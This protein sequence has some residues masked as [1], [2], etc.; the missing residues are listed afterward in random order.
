MNPSTQAPGT[1][2][3]VG[4]CLLSASAYA[5]MHALPVLMAAV[6]NE[7]RTAVSDAGWLVTAYM[8]GQ[9]IA[10]VGLPAARTHLHKSWHGA[11]ACAFLI[12]ALLMSA[13]ASGAL[14]V[15]AWLL[16]GLA[17]GTLYYHSTLVVA[18]FPNAALAFSLRLSLSLLVSA[19]TLVLIYALTGGATY[20]QIVHG[21]VVGLA[22]FLAAGLVFLRPAARREGSRQVHGGADKQATVLLAI[23]CLLFVGQI[24]YWAFALK[25]ANHSGISGDTA[26]ASI[27]ACKAMAACIIFPLAFSDRTAR[28]AT[29]FVAPGALVAAGIVITTRSPDLWLLV[30]GLLVWEIG[31]NVLAARLQ[32]RA[33]QLHA[34]YSGSWITAV[35]FLGA[36]AGPVVQGT[37]MEYGVQGLF[38]AFAIATALLPWA[39]ER[40]ASRSGSGRMRREWTR[41]TNAS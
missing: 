5:P 11:I 14:L 2:P 28:R 1:R 37:A 39:W 34:G 21:L 26:V 13:G 15:L 10:A 29:G 41:P 25:T 8:T 7:E 35:I 31:F 40:V 17:S 4:A 19:M 6:V 22:L 30:G 16:A 33:V 23:L 9:L 32:A 38:I 20:A 36:G 3:L 27:A 18:S 12:V 24:G